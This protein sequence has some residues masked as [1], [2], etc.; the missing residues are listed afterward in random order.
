M[1]SGVGA[2]GRADAPGLGDP[3]AGP[4]DVGARD[5][6]SAPDVV[7]EP[8]RLVFQSVPAG[9]PV[10]R[11]FS[12]TNLGSDAVAVLVLPTLTSRFCSEDTPQVFCLPDEVP[13]RFDFTLPSGAGGT[14][15]VPVRYEP[16]AGSRRDTGAVLVQVCEGGSECII[17][18]ALAGTSA[19]APFDC[20]PDSLEFGGVNSGSCVSLDAACTY[21]GPDPLIILDAGPTQRTDPAF[22]VDALGFSNP[23]SAGDAVFPRATFCGDRSSREREGAFRIEFEVE[24]RTGAQDLLLTA[25]SGGPDIRWSPMSL[26]FPRCSLG[27]SC[28]ARLQVENR[29]DEPLTVD[30]DL[31]D[32]PPFPLVADPSALVLDPAGRGTIVFVATR[33]EPGTQSTRVELATNDADSPSISVPVVLGG[34]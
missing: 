10:E 2:C 7:V 9:F 15:E 26:G 32:E 22:D 29:G 34:R 33:T 24:G 17:D 27:R 23:L 12:V 6:G 4:T 8:R 21:V 20:V 31:P 13:G 5:A 30:V 28:Q 16:G 25:R 19:T 3:D 18:V 1:F 14:R 11:R